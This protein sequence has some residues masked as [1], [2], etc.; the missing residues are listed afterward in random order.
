MGDQRRPDRDKARR[1]EE[2]V[3]AKPADAEHEQDFDSHAQKQKQLRTLARGDVHPDLPERAFEGAGD[4]EKLR[5]R[6][7]AILDAGTVADG[8]LEIVRDFDGANRAYAGTELGR[9]AKVVTG[10]D[11]LVIAE[12]ANSLPGATVDAALACAV[13]PTP[14][15]MRGFLSRMSDD[16][17]RL[18]LGDAATVTK[19]RAVYKSPISIIPQLPELLDNEHLARWY[20]TDTPHEQIAMAMIRSEDT[21]AAKARA[22][23]MDKAGRGAWMWGMHVTDAMTAINRDIVEAFAK[24]TSQA[25]VGTFLQARVD[26]YDKIGA[27]VAKMSKSEDEMNAE[28]KKGKPNIDDVVDDLGVAVGLADES[29]RKNRARFLGA[30]STRQ[31][32]QATQLANFKPNE[33]MDWLLDGKNVVVDELRDV[34]AA[35]PTD[36]VGIGLDAKLVGKVRKRWPEASPADVL[37]RVPD[38]LYGTMGDNT[39]VRTW[40]VKTGQ[41]SDILKLLTIWPGATAA[42]CKWIDAHG[43]DWLDRI[44]GGLDD[45]ALRVLL[46][47]CPDEAIKSRIQKYL[48][49]D[50]LETES[51]MTKAQPIDRSAN[52]DPNDR[53]ARE[54][55]FK[56]DG[57]LADAAGELRA[58]DVAQLKRDPEQM[59]QAI[60]RTKGRHLVRVLYL[61]DPPLR[62][63]LTRESKEEG[64]V[65]VANVGGWVSTRPGSDVVDALSDPTAAANAAKMWPAAPL[66]VMPQLR[67]AAV[68]AKVLDANTDVLR[69]ILEGSEPMSALHAIGASGVSKAT[70]AA[71]EEDDSLLELLP[72]GKR[73]SPR[74]RTY[75][76]GLANNASGSLKKSIMDRIESDESEDSEFDID[77]RAN[78]D[79]RKERDK[80]GFAEALEAILDDSAARAQDIVTLCRE[81]AADASK[82]VETQ[83]E[84]VA[85]VLERTKLSPQIVFATVPLHLLLAKAELVE[86]T[87]DSVPSFVVLRE[88]ATSG[89]LAS[90]LAKNIDARQQPF[91]SW[92]RRLPSASGLSAVETAGL[93]K[94]FEGIKGDESARDAFKARFG[95]NVTDKYTRA[96]LGR[97]W[98]TLERVPRAHADQLATSGFYE[99]ETKPVDGEFSP[100]TRQVGIKEGLIDRKGK[101]DQNP[102]YDRGDAAST[103]MTKEQAKTAFGLD[104]KQLEQWV[105]EQRLTLKNGVYTVNPKPQQDR[106][107]GTALHEVGHAVDQM[108]G[109]NTQLVFG[110]ADW[111]QYGDGDMEAWAN[112]LGGW[113][114]VSPADK[115]KIREAF[116]VWSN[117]SQVDHRPPKQ[118]FELVASDHPVRKASYAG[119][120]IVDFVN[121]PDGRGDRGAPF[122]RNGRAYMMNGLYQRRY[123]VPMKTVHAS[124]STYSLAAPEEWFAECYM[125][126]Y[127]TYD[128]T[129]KTAGEKGKLLAPWIKKWFDD[130]IDK[131]GHN[132]SRNKYDLEGG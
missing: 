31:I 104:D 28:L 128:G 32:D 103:E 53:F 102:V 7:D 54:V 46:L 27:D 99:F 115:V 38:S 57:D 13:K 118:M 87:F 125:T 77:E 74:E 88:A 94:I 20:F 22:K 23:H 11:M 60:A 85:K 58:E 70:V 36:E 63:L 21:G 79:D 95:S 112:D 59:K 75:L 4:Q 72:S 120:G 114:R 91:V 45:S 61:L 106:F 16:F 65:N 101:D 50:H 97:L 122:L 12:L 52:E 78:G 116:L 10:G 83:P 73:L 82:L 71:L 113:D 64:E 35:W 42:R 55:R 81:R 96:E 25:D 76:Y 40:I 34:L 24:A 84:L 92:V 44:G 19:L 119:V 69:W 8:V 121:D 43:W 48:L 41:P 15:E 3:K 131:I 108:L 17:L 62:L 49:G 98:S 90:L 39:I 129:P 29:L 26:A 6:F 110:L 9:L 30:A 80:A 107:T 86:P 89:A 66:E 124:P 1:D 123:S 111:K 127:L 67:Q 117:S 130:N 2:P 5:E 51:E 132:P 100:A 126:Y 47:Q 18:D 68:L 14:N 93:K 37:G 56:K 109:N 105:T 33:R